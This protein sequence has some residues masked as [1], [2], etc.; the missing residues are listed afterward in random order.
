MKIL[1][2]CNIML[3]VISRNLRREVNPTGGWLSGLSEDLL[4]RDSIKLVVCF[5]MK[6]SND[7]AGQINKLSYYGKEL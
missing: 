3:P 7:I 5:P 4:K 1:W 6:K 2:L